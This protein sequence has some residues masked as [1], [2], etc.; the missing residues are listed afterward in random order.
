MLNIFVE[1]SRVER[2]L[3]YEQR[4]GHSVPIKSVVNASQTAPLKKAE[5]S[6]FKALS[7]V[8]GL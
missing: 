4:I 6:I 7:E 5:E 8:L 2:Q 1:R 3:Y